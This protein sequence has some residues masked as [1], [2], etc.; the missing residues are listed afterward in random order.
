M[1]FVVSIIL[2]LSLFQLGSAQTEYKIST[3]GFTFEKPVENTVILKIYLSVANIGALE[4]FPGE[5]KKIKLKSSNYN[6]AKDIFFVDY[7]KIIGNGENLTNFSVY[8]LSFLIP[9]DAANIKIVFP[10]RYGGLT[11]D[12]TKKNYY[13]WSKSNSPEEREKR[14]TGFLPQVH[15]TKYVG[16]GL[17]L[18]GGILNNSSTRS[19]VRTIGSIGFE[20]LPRLYNFGKENR[21]AVFATA[22][23][24]YG[25]WLNK[26]DA[27]GFTGFYNPDTSIYK[28]I[29]REKADSSAVPYFSYGG[30]LGVFIYLGNVNPMLSISYVNT[31]FSERKMLLKVN[32]TLTELPKYD[33]WGVKVD[34]GIE[35]SNVLLAYTFRQFTTESNYSFLNKQHQMH[36]FKVALW[37]WS[38]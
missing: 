33:G 21:S 8:A 7:K 14:K 11:V 16:F 18:E 37:G 26:D 34:V 31:Q 38:Y 19:S 36:L 6:F 2:F 27:N 9:M 23:I 15:F 22:N 4:E 3:E 28:V 5:V 30:G 12:V 32:N 17:S 10:E 13:E 25:G 20:I 35:F 29:D 24:N 1:K